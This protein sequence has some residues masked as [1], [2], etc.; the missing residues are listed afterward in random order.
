MALSL[1][2]MLLYSGWYL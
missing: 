1:E 2:I